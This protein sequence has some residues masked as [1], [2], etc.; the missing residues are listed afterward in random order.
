[1]DEVGT[2]ENPIILDVISICCDF[3]EYKNIEEYIKDYSNQHEEKTEDETEEE[4]SEKIEE[5]ISEKTTLIK[6]REDIDEGF[7]IKQI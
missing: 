4:Y 2:P 3:S 6:F 1:L 5:E 7:I